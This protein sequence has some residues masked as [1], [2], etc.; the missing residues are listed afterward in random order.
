[1]AIFYNCYPMYGL[2]KYR[3]FL[4]APK[5][6]CGCKSPMHILLKTE[7][8]VDEFCY[9]MLTEHDCPNSAIFSVFS[10]ETFMSIWRY[11]DE[12]EDTDRFYKVKSDDPHMFAE[13][14]GEFR[15]CCYN[16][17][18]EDRPGEWMIR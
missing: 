13:I 9:A 10:D 17:I 11:Y 14:D 7:E 6:E 4:E 15:F 5:C 1:M 2:N 12:D 16:L 18:V 8:D 3:S